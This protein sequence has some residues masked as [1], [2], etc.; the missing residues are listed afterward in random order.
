MQ[1][2]VGEQD[3][4]HWLITYPPKVAMFRLVN[5]LKGVSS[6]LI[7]QKDSPPSSEHCWGEVFGVRVILRARQEVPHALSFDNMLSNRRLR[8][9]RFA[10]APDIP[11]LN[12]GVLRRILIKMR[13]LHS[14]RICFEHSL[15]SFVGQV[16]PN[17]GSLGMWVRYGVQKFSW[18]RHD[19]GIGVLVGQ[20]FN[21]FMRRA[22][23]AAA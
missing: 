2:F 11:G 12:D 18:A 16:H 21:H 20:G 4:V 1:G 10:V 17:H 8:S 23:Q 5:R 7:R 3:P 14:P 15:P 6:R 22:S 9:N 19:P 13:C